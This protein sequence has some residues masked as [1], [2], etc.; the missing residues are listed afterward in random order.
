MSEPNITHNITTRPKQG[1][2]GC[3][4]IIGVLLLFVALGTATTYGLRFLGLS[5]DKLEVRESSVDRE[6]NSNVESK[7]E[8][9]SINNNEIVNNKIDNNN[10]DNKINIECDSIS[11]VEEIRPDR[12]IYR[13]SSDNGCNML[14][15]DR[16]WYPFGR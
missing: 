12:N 3:V 4:S 14:N 2:M 11:E 6:L 8:E 15:G 5:K 1:A 7:V 10:E 16:C 13:Y 9:D